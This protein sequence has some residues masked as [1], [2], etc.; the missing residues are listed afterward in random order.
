MTVRPIAEAELV[1]KKHSDGIYAC[2]QEAISK[3]IIKFG[4]G[5]SHLETGTKRGMVR[6][7]IVEELQSYAEKTSGVQFF[8]KGNL[9]YFGFDNNWHLK[10]KHID[11]RF[12]VGVSPTRD[13]RSYNKN[14]IPEKIV[15]DIVG[16]EPTA[17]YLGWNT[18][19]NAPLE[20]QVSLVCNNENGSVEWVIPIAGKGLPPALEFPAPETGDAPGTRVR[21]RKTAK[22][23][24]KNG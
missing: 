15:G 1:F 21:V 6:D 13:S 2:V 16:A 10:V 17:L 3:Y 24:E 22:T 11:E 23:T 8:K 7:L 14:I 20:P 19:D 5:L 12:R 18:T 4:A 9:K